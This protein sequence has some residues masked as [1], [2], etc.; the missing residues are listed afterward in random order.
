MN[1]PNHFDIENKL[2]SDKTS[3][4]NKLL[5][6]LYYVVVCFLKSFVLI[7][8]A[9]TIVII[10]FKQIGVEIKMKNILK[11]FYD[12]NVKNITFSTSKYRPNTNITYIDKQ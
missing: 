6:K 2:L 5:L 11:T 1:I 9:L 8:L 3:R 7:A 10:L 12:E 4:C